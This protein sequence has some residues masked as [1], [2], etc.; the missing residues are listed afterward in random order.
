MKKILILLDNLVLILQYRY[1]LQKRIYLKADPAMPIKNPTPNRYV[2]SVQPIQATFPIEYRLQI[3]VPRI[4]SHSHIQALLRLIIASINQHISVKPIL[5]ISDKVTT[6]DCYNYNSCR[7]EPGDI[8]RSNSHRPCGVRQGTPL[9]MQSTY[10]QVMQE[11]AETLKRNIV[12]F[13]L[14]PAA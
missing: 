3:Y 8:L 12:I 4:Q 9:P 2:F 7:Y 11:M 10:C 5:L 6:I 13:N 14:D 1:Q